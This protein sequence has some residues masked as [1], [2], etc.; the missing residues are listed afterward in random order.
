MDKIIVLDF[1]SQTSQLI[2]R[3][4]REA[5]I[6]CEVLPGDTIA[7]KIDKNRLK[8]LIF[9]GSPESVYDSGATAVDKEFYNTGVPILG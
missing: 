1:G 2:S 5:G 4:I 6:F 8:G 3:R 7:G 9:S